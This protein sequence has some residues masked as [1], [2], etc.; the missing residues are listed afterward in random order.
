MHL[1]FLALIVII[2]TMMTT[3]EALFINLGAVALPA[4]TGSALVD[5]AGLAGVGA[6][7]TGALV[8]G[9]LF[10]TVIESTR[11]RRDTGA[12]EDE[13]INNTLENVLNNEPDD[14]YKRVFCAIGSGQ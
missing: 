1:K 11:R 10:G 3:N 14:C 7:F 8:P 13:V 9:I 5:L 6:L 4:I 2:S 12:L